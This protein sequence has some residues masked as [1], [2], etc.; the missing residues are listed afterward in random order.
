MT[1][2]EKNEKLLIDGEVD[3][4]PLIAADTIHCNARRNGR[5]SYC[6]RQPGWG[7]NHLSTGRC[8]LHGGSRARGIPSSVPFFL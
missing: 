3:E 2:R 4:L 7:T 5:R 1:E 8:K 6:K